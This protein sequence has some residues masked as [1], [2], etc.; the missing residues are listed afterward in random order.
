MLLNP[1]FFQYV[2]FVVLNFS[3][4]V[5]VCNYKIAFIMADRMEKKNFIRLDK[6]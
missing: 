2:C 4:P 6:Q 1:L 3:F 5:F